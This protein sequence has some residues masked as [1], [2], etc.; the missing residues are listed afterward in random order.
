MQWV[1]VESFAICHV[2]LGLTRFQ[3]D[4][5]GFDLDA[6]RFT[7]FYPVFQGLTLIY[8]VLPGFTGFQWDFTE[9]DL[10]ALRF[11]GFYL[12]FN[13]LTLIYLTLT[14]FHEI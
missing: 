10:D 13:G 7:G 9:F 4:F 8:F 2:A 6:L 5:T 3:W 11:T 14:R 12:V 1:L